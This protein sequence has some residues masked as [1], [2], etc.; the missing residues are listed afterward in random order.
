MKF[1][2]TIIIIIISNISELI[3]NENVTDLKQNKNRYILASYS[4]LDLIIQ[5]KYGLNFGFINEYNIYNEPYRSVEIDIM[6]SHVGK[7]TE[8]MEDTRISFYKRVIT[9]EIMPQLFYGCSYFDTLVNFGNNR[10]GRLTGGYYN[11]NI[12]YRFQSLGLNI[13]LGNRWYVN[14]NFIFSIDWVSWAQP[15]YILNKYSNYLDTNLPVSERD[16]F[17]KASTLTLINYF[18]RFTFLKLQIG[19]LF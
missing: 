12:S 14:E 6:H 19:I 10:I 7:T 9:K 3:A 11:S 1:I 8:Y 16:N 17:V 4:N 2:I 5:N 15:I 13:G 18:P